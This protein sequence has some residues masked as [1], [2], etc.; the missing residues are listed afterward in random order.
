MAGETRMST[1]AKEIRELGNTGYLEVD[2]NGNVGIGS[3]GPTTK[4]EITEASGYTGYEFITLSRAEPTRY[5]S[6]IGFGDYAGGNNFGLSFTTR[7][8]NVDYRTMTMVDGKVGIGTENPIGRLQV[9]TPTDTTIRVATSSGTRKSWNI[10]NYYDTWNGLSSPFIIQPI[11]DSGN[12]DICITPVVNSPSDGLVIYKSGLSRFK[13]TDNRVIKQWAPTGNYSNGTAYV[14][15]TRSEIAALGYGDGMYRFVIFSNTFNAGLSHYSTFVAYDPFYF[16]N[17][18]SNAPQA[19]TFNWS[20]VA[21]G[22][23]PNTGTRAADLVIRH[24]YGADGTYPAN[25]TFEFIPT[26]GLSNLNSAGGY[27]FYIRLYKIG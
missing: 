10:G 14:F 16:T 2:A 25:Q 15:S 13:A 19:F 22:H 12:M 6:T 17:T 3:T 24:K 26:A 27:E 5:R 8:N 11:E 21:M 9:E 1:R 4:L 7:N 20:G 23:A 18:G